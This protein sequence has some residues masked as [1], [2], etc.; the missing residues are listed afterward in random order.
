MT[1]AANSKVRLLSFS[2]GG[3]ALAIDAASVSEVVRRP[4]VTRVPQAPAALAGVANV[5]GRV[6]PV[7]NLADLLQAPGA[8]EDGG[9]LIVVERPEP[10]A[11]A[12]DAVKALGADADGASRLDLDTL[13]A[14]AFA[15]RS[16]RAPRRERPA[17]AGAA[18]PTLAARKPILR[19]EIAGQAYG[20]PL[21]AVREVREAPATVLSLSTAETAV[22]G[23]VENRGRLLPVVRPDVLLGLPPRRG[24]GGR[25]VVLGLGAAALG[26]LVE[27]VDDIVRVAPERIVAAPAILNRGAGEARIESVARTEHGLV[28]LISP[29]RLFRDEVVTP[30]LNDGY[31]E[32]APMAA[33]ALEQL[34]VFRLAEE[35]Y[36]LPIDA[37]DEVVRY[38]E[39]I[40]R[41]P[42]APAFLAGVANHRGEALP[43]VDQRIRFAVG[44][45][46]PAT[47]RRVI[48]ARVDG[49][50]VGFAVDAVEALRA[51]AADE[52]SETPDIAAGEGRLFDR[53]ASVEMDGRLVLLVNPRELLDQAERDL[54]AAVS[55]RA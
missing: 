15:G 55:E 3:K 51:V 13:L 24:T 40:T 21:E 47:G 34:L 4:P 36:A 9:R 7:I 50:R 44:G 46:I 48:V 42:Q 29:D 11:L 35:T 32:S 38:P 26:L 10:M 53:V 6:L 23:V 37:V 41:V 27:R 12:V 25:I 33:A 54:V 28:A 8:A 49:V 52:L 14:R 30:M 2:V 19:F 43:I 22:A 45:T 39:A 1:A 20:L 5:R 16:A 31:E 17:A 18:A